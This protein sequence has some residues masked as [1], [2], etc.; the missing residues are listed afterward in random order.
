[1]LGVRCWCT[2]ASIIH[3]CSLMEAL[4]LRCLRGAYA[5]VC[6]TRRRQECL[7]SSKRRTSLLLNMPVHS[8]LVLL[9]AFFSL[10]E[11]T[12][13]DKKAFAWPYTFQ[14]P[15][16]EHRCRPTDWIRPIMRPRSSRTGTKARERVQKS[17]DNEVHL[18]GP[19]SLMRRSSMT[20]GHRKR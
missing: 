9:H 1:M 5:G 4:R 16:I 14:A 2:V 10:S 12:E 6:L 7:V 18:G 11:F 20:A 19:W 8:I 13:S 17:N 3:Q 15:T